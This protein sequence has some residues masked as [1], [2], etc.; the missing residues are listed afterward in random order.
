MLYVESWTWR[1]MDYYA[2]QASARKDLPLRLWR[3]ITWSSPEYAAQI[4]AAAAQAAAEGRVLWVVSNATGRGHVD[5]T[6]DDRFSGV[7][8]H[9][10]TSTTERFSQVTLTRFLPGG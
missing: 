9:Y 1:A 6:T 7:R 5:P 8:R 4:E 3:D 2:R 10:P